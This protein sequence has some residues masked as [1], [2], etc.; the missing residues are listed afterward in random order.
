MIKTILIEFIEISINN[1]EWE[2]V[3]VKL[4]SLIFVCNVIKTIVITKKEIYS[5]TDQSTI[6]NTSK[7]ETTG[8]NICL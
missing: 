8:F 6:I 1:L 2:N 3:K 7:E 4:Q 5:N